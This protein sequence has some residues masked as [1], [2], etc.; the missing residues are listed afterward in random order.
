MEEAEEAY[1]RRDYR[2]TVSSSQLSVENSA[3]AVIAIFRIPSW[4]HDPS[5]ELRELIDQLPNR[6]KEFAEKLAEMAET[7]APEHGRSTYGEPLRGLTPW[8]IY[9]ERDA[10]TA[11]NYARN[12]IEYAQKILNA[13]RQ[14]A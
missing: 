6:V 2:G 11:L 4:S 1:R 5:I 9:G 3:K 10:H 14:T 8:E 13:L 12:S 7:L